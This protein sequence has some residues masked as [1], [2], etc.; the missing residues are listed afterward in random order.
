MKGLLLKDFYMA[1][2]YCKSYLL[3]L[4][5]FLA[6]SV[7]DDDN[8]FF[9]FYPCVLCGMLPVNLLSYD[10]KSKWQL[11]CGTLPYTKAQ[12]VSSKFLMGLF[13]QIFVLLVTGIAHA[14]RMV[15]TDSFI[16]DDYIVL[17]LLLFI[18]STITC[19]ATL[20][21]IFKFGVEKGRIAYYVLIA[22]VCGAGGIATG[23]LRSQK[24]NIIQFDTILPILCL[25]GVGIYILFWYLSIVFYKK[26][27]IH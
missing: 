25:V 21:F 2:K 24:M 23:L 17:L 18:I 19:S 4:V 8:M 10:E 9:I 14:V 1:K 15:M 11:Y 5:C 26:R 7:M 6:L 3:L 20:P 16:A 13:A 22:L 27:D 12:I